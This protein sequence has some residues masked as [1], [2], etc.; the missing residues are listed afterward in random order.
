[1]DGRGLGDRA[2]SSCS[3]GLRGC[4]CSRVR[5]WNMYTLPN[6]PE[7]REDIPAGEASGGGSSRGR[8]NSPS[9]YRNPF[10]WGTTITHKMVLPWKSAEDWCRKG[11]A[12]GERGQYDRAIE[13]YDRALKLNANAANAWY[14][15]GRVLNTA[16][17]Y[18]EAAECFDQGIRID[19]DCARLWAARGQVLYHLQ[20]YQE[21]AGYCGQAVKLAPGCADAWLIRGHAFRNLGRTTDALACYD[22]VVTIEPG[23]TEAWLARGTVLAVDRRYDA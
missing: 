3:S 7:L 22:R 5:P 20:H 6:S 18:L 17:R 13:C 9:P 21:A 23:R 1:M 11:R 14:H 16:C 10:V 15:K 2:S 8:Q 19:P 4:S 12:Y